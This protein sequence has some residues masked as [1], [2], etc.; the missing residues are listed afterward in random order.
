[1]TWASHEIYQI[2]PGGKTE[3]V[4]FGLADKFV[5]LDGIDVLGDGTFVISDF[6]A[7]RLYTVAPDRKTVKLLVEVD[8]PADIIIDRQRNLL[9]APSYKSN[10][11]TIYKLHGPGGK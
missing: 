4:A 11:I 7:N 2:D 3:P 10:E 8:T 9:Y 1:M 6:K 5:N